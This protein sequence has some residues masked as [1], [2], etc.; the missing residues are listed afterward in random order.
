MPK[1]NWRELDWQRAVLRLIGFAL[2]GLC[3]AFLSN[4]NLLRGFC[5]GL[6]TGGLWLAGW[7]ED[8]SRK[9]AFSSQP[10]TPPAAEEEK[11]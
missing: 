2:S 7:M 9:D 4:T 5:G 3:L 1:L 8:P 6:A 11:Q 10:L